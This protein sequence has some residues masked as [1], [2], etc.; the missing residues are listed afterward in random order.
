MTYLLAS[1]R[2]HQ[3]GGPPIHAAPARHSHTH[4]PRPTH[5]G[6]SD[7]GR[8]KAVRPRG[9]RPLRALRLDPRAAATNQPGREETLSPTSAPSN[10]FSRAT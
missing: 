6:G 5:H 7:L 4:G 9:Y 1:I 3:S 10:N 2:I 8:V